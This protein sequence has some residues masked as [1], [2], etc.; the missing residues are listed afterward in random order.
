MSN[1]PGH[2]VASDLRHDIITL[3]ATQR[4]DVVEH[5]ITRPDGTIA[6]CPAV[7]HPGAVVILPVLADGSI[8][9]IHSHRVTIGRTIVELPAGT[10]EPDEPPVETAGR[11]LEEETGYRAGRIE[12]LAEFYS[13]PGLSDERMHAY[14]ATELTPGPP[15][16]EPNEQIEN[17]VVA[18]D[19]VQG[20]I[21][22]GEIE[23][24]KTL[25]TLLLYERRGK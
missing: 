3:F 24:A 21:D 22:R 23:D 11:E 1:E 7:T 8:C 16:R 17:F 14:V 10:R 12:L 19:D 15:R 6:T 9:L 13:S 20:M 25:A 2:D 4:F 18:W 5:R